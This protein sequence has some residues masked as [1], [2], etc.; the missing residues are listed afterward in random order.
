MKRRFEPTEEQAKHV[1]GPVWW[2][3]PT[4][5]Q[6]KVAVDLSLDTFFKELRS[7]GYFA[8]F[9]ADIYRYLLPFVRSDHL[10]PISSYRNTLLRA[11][12]FFCNR[13]ND[14]PLPKYF[15]QR[16]FDYIR[17][18]CLYLKRWR[19]DY[20]S[21]GMFDYP[22]PGWYDA[23]VE[24]GLFLFP[25]SPFLL[26]ETY[27]LA[28]DMVTCVQLC[29]DTLRKREV[30]RSPPLFM[31]LATF[32]DELGF[33]MFVFDGVASEIAPHALFG[34]KPNNHPYYLLGKNYSQH[35]IC[36]VVSLL[37]FIVRTMH[38]V[39]VGECNF[40]ARYC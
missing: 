16:M 29:K 21:I 2:S 13:F 23:E 6:F 9:C 5:M 27:N 4:E 32:V 3:Y 7:Y 19:F 15:L 34:R 8:L 40:A 35:S 33:P 14:P 25:C 20:F 30:E 24:D 38:D 37:S 22:P 28:L 1:S 36:S 17:C 18:P 12:E 26:R 39:W 11:K 10:F 31:E